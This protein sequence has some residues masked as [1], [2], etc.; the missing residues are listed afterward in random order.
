MSGLW[1]KRGGCSFFL[2]HLL[3]LFFDWGITWNFRNFGIPG[4]AFDFA[5]TDMGRVKE[6]ARTLESQQKG[7]KKKVNPK[8]LNMIDM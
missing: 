6:K 1:R 4:S 5:A 8:V 2:R 3:E 7:M